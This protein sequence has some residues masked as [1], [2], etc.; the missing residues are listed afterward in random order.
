MACVEDDIME[1][2]A[3]EFEKGRHSK[4]K[5]RWE[6]GMRELHSLFRNSWFE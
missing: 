6:E 4:S 5:V 2:E 3:N 1:R